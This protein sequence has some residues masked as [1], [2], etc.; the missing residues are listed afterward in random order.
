MLLLLTNYNSKLEQ[1]EI[2]RGSD[3]FIYN[4]DVN[5]YTKQYDTN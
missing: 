5:R 2:L 1:T 4:V 3:S